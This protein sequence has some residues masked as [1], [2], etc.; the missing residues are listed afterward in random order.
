MTIYQSEV[1]V[2]NG[3]YLPDM[4]SVVIPEATENMVTNPS[5][6]MNATGYTAVGAGAAITRVNTDQRRG[7]Y[8]LQIT[9][10]AGVASGA[11]FGTVTLV[12][13]QSY[14]F[15]ID[16]HGVAGHWYELYFAS[17]AAVRLGSP[18]RFQANGYW[19]RVSITYFETAGA[20]RRLYIVQDANADVRPFYV[21]GWQCENKPYPTTYCDGDLE[22]FVIGETAYGWNGTYHGSTSFRTA[23]TRSG[24]RIINLKNY[25]FN[26]LG[27]MGLGLAP[28]TNYSLPSNLGGAYYQNT[29]NNVR[30]FTLIGDV[31]EE[32]NL[33]LSD[34]RYKLETAFRHD[35]TPYRQPLLLHFQEKDGCGK[36]IGDEVF[37]KCLYDGGL[38]RTYDNL[39]GEKLILTFTAFDKDSIWI[40]GEYARA[41]QY[42]QS[43]NHT[44]ISRIS[45]DGEWSTFGSGITNNAIYC[46]VTDENGD[47]YAGGAFTT[48]DGVAANRI[49]K[50]TNGAWTAL[51]VGTDGTVQ[52]MAIKNGILYVG[53]SFANA[54]GG[55]AAKIA[56]YNTITS[57]WSALGAGLAG[58]DC[59][60]IFVNSDNSYLYAGGAFTTAGGAAATRI[61][62]WNI[63]TGAWSTLAMG[64]SEGCNQVVLDITSN[65]LT[66]IWC[67]GSFTTAGGISVNYIARWNTAGAWYALGTGLAGGTTIAYKLLF[68]KNQELLV[69]GTFTTAGGIACTNLAMWNG[70]AWKGLFSDLRGYITNMVMDEKNLLH[71]VGQYQL[72][73]SISQK[74]LIYHVLSP[75]SNDAINKSHAY[76]AFGPYSLAIGYDILIDAIGGIIMV[77]NYNYLQVPVKNTYSNKSSIF[78][79][80]DINNASATRSSR[81]LT[82][83]IVYD[84][85]A[86]TFFSPLLVSERSTVEKYRWKSNYS[87]LTQYLSKE[88]SYFSLDTGNQNLYAIMDT[89]YSITGDGGNQIANGFLITG[90]SRSNTNAGVLYLSVVAD[91]AGFYHI[92]MYKAAARLAGDLV[93]HTASVNAVTTQ[94]VIADNSSGLSGYITFTPVAADVDIELSFS[95]LDI[96]MRYRNYIRSLSNARFQ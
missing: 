56:K 42:N 30:S 80:F 96:T 12:T 17:A 55:A 87:N 22:G 47:L 93:A 10:A 52:C 36:V 44:F 48:I 46:I 70:S 86:I 90:L 71:I 6:E 83:E 28:V 14:T 32:T 24:G 54:G 18:Y 5:F 1:D 89:T 50:F 62:K 95:I 15:S 43:I 9:P 27:S 76:R 26:L 58:G 79:K 91:G 63:S 19:Q 64:A 66:D 4:F 77:G 61:A 69:G 85:E 38:E 35:L 74:V 13:G 11:Y 41:L 72:W 67:C 73:D 21:D 25:K 37:I 34:A 3:I 68:T 20:A 53:G 23:T 33:L 49:A 16:I 57:T 92:N 51:G 94:V 31:I 45:P 84:E 8:S 40:D 39:N 82:L 65:N 2:I 7:S 81:P 78:P 88:G 75:Y 29:I 60:T 59:M